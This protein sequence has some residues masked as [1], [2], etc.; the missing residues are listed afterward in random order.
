MQKTDTKNLDELGSGSAPATQGGTQNLVNGQKSITDGRRGARNSWIGTLV[1]VALIILVLLFVFI[2]KLRATWVPATNKILW[3][4]LLAAI[5]LTGIYPLSYLAYL[6]FGAEAQ[7]RRLRTDFQLFGLV[8]EEKLEETIDK[9]Y[10]NVYSWPQFIIYIVLILSISLLIVLGYFERTRLG[11]VSPGVMEV[12]F[13]GYLGTYVFSVQE[14]VRRYNTFDLQPQVYS[15]ILVRILITLALTFVIGALGIDRGEALFAAQNSEE[16]PQY[17]AATWMLLVAFAVGIFPNS[18][19]RWLTAQA[20]RVM[21]RSNER[22]SELAVR[23]LLGVSQWHEARLSMMG[24]DDAQN[25]ATADLPRMLLTTQFDTQQVANWIDQAILYVKVGDK[26]ERFREAKIATFSELLQTLG[27]AEL[28]AAF[29]LSE[30]EGNKPPVMRSSLATVL[31]LTDP[32]ELRRLCNYA[33]YPNFNHIIL[34]YKGMQ[35]VG[36]QRAEKSVQKLTGVASIDRTWLSPLGERV[37]DHDLR[38]DLLELIQQ[39]H[40]SFI[41]AEDYTRRGVIYYQ[42][43]DQERARQS[44]TA[45]SRW[46][47]ATKRPI[48]G[49]ASSTWTSRN[50]PTRSGMSPKPS[51]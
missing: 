2:P 47:A 48:T 13:F 42:L 35:R 14:L 45:P 23:H 34:Y 51:I 12:I 32:D 6:G 40:G 5:G 25:L 31:G 49:A 10:Q 46:T 7:R 3:V 44:F 11:I 33:N 26:I 27:E 4:D 21:N 29:E 38:Q 9:L 24:I 19:V 36:S 50:T 16:L 22:D 1:M 41:T 28:N 43:H 39:T 17:G 8:P 20:N 30:S 37:P 18:G 15:S